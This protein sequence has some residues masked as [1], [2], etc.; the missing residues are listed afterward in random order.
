MTRAGTVL[1]TGA[2][3]FIGSVTVAALVDAGWVVT[4][5]ARSPQAFLGHRTTMLD[6]AQPESLLKLASG[7]RFDAI[8]HL[9]AQVVLSS[10]TE[11]D[12][13]TPNVLSTACLAYLANLWGAR[14]I[15][16]S[17]VIVHGARTEKITT[18]SPVCTDT[19]YARTKY[20][21]EQ[22]LASSGVNYCALRIAGVFGRNGPSHLGLNR[23]I[24][25]AL[26]GEAP[27]QI[28]LGAAMRNYVY[29]KDVAAAVVHALSVP[30]EGVHLLA[31]HEVLSMGEMLNLVCE[32]LAPDL[33]P[34]IKPGPQAGDQVIVPS[35]ALP[36][37]RSFRDALID[38]SSEHRS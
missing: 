26:Q 29:V 24:A 31:G 3:G 32:I 17:T 4:C 18:D 23:A 38:M 20:L 9:G 22:L 37:T 6:L 5:G 19:A 15:F 2:T 10:A 30:I 7:E 34:V 28:G 36:N 21:G 11:A 16:A 12:M 8:V 33:R 1:V 14:L 25:G 35:I 13:Y 27:I